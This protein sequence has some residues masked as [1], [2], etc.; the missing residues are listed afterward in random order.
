MRN[1]WLA[2]LMKSSLASSSACS[3]ALESR[4]CLTTCLFSSKSNLL[5]S[6]T[7]ILSQTLYFY[8]VSTVWKS[9]W[10]ADWRSM[11]IRISMCSKMPYNKTIM[12]NILGHVFHFFSCQSFLCVFYVP[13]CSDSV[14]PPC[15]SLCEKAKDG[16]NEILNRFGFHWPEKFNCS[17]FPISEHVTVRIM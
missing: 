3:L 14:L 17:I 1:W 10:Y 16:C 5:S 7:P 12:P 15:R 4:N 11:C 2:I 8:T 13:P 9:R 6:A